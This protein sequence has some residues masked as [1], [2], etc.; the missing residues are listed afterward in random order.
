MVWS[1]TCSFCPLC[2]IVGKLEYL[3]CPA[4]FWTG[5][6]RRRWCREGPCGRVPRYEIQDGCQ[7]L[8]LPAHLGMLHSCK[9][10]SPKGSQGGSVWWE[11]E[12]EA[13]PASKKNVLLPTD[14][15]RR[16]CCA[17]PPCCAGLAPRADSGLRAASTL[18]ILCM[19]SKDSALGGLQ[20]P[21]RRRDD[22]AG[23][24]TPCEWDIS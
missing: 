8:C 19:V 10:P 11:W 6:Q 4:R 20:L 9:M 13:V 24:S 7:G 14:P 12:M 21:S 2:P 5:D 22:K 16:P 3:D 23:R 18:T 1:L 17:P 15:C